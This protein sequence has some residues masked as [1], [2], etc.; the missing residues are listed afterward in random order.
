MRALATALVVLQACS[1]PADRVDDAAVEPDAEQPCGNGVV[2]GGE[3]CDEGAKNGTS[4]VLCTRQCRSGLLAFDTPRTIRV[5]G[6]VAELAELKPYNIA[7]ATPTRDAVF[8]ALDLTGLVFG[9]TTSPIERTF[10]M[11]GQVRSLG[12]LQMG[13]PE[14]SGEGSP[15][16]IEK[17][18]Q[19]VQHLY[20]AVVSTNVIREIPYPFSDGTNGRI[21]TNDTFAPL[22]VDVNPTTSELLVAAV[23]ASR[24]DDIRV[25]S[26]RFPAP[27]VVL[28]TSIGSLLYEDWTEAPVRSHRVLQF[29]DDTKTFAMINVQLDL[30]DV[31]AITTP[32]SIQLENVGTWPLRVVAGVQWSEGICASRPPAPK[33][34][35]VSHPQPFAVLTDTG[36]VYIWQFNASPDP[37]P[38]SFLTPFAKLTSGTKILSSWPAN[39]VGTGEPLWALE[40]DGTQVGMSDGDNADLRSTSLKLQRAAALQPFTSAVN[41]PPGRNNGPG[42]FA[43]DDLLFTVP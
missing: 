14:V 36:E 10:S 17:D 43:V 39:E 15:L 1:S 34:L 2:D 27:G 20:Y 6:R 5:A 26:G 25:P 22:V 3:S 35:E 9:T 29:F 4:D 33:C 13:T 30:S 40:P 31:Y 24:N 16:W 7:Y 37:S 12:R 38:E 42:V 32:Y 11:G 23:I 41:S 28:G 21:V 8:V 19:G 18:T